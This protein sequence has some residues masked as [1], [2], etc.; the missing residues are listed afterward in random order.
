MQSNTKSKPDRSSQSKWSQS[1]QTG[2]RTTQS[3]QHRDIERIFDG[4]ATKRGKAKRNQRGAKGLTHQ[5]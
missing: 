1:E 3:N 5:A 4:M 2:D